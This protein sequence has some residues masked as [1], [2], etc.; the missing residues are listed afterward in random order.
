MSTFFSSICA[1]TTKLRMSTAAMVLATESYLRS[2]TYSLPKCSVTSVMSRYTPMPSTF[3]AP[4]LAKSER[5]F[6]HFSSISPSRRAS[7]RRVTSH[8]EQRGLPSKISVS[9]AAAGDAS[10][11]IYGDQK[12]KG[13]AAQP[14][15]ADPARA[16]R[17][18]ALPCR[19]RGRLQRHDDHGVLV[20]GRRRVPR[21]RRG[22]RAALDE[23]VRE[24]ADRGLPRPRRDSDQ[25]AAARPAP[26]S[27]ARPRR[28]PPRVH[29]RRG[30]RRGGRGGWRPRGQ[31]GGRARGVR[32]GDPRREA[33]KAAA[34]P[35]PAQHRQPRGR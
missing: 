25:A 6:T 12:L 22:A 35:L 23:R 33:A 34:H 24:R 10:E 8:T 7:M 9:L 26:Q 3:T 17:R 4:S 1:T 20:R 27:H 11:A 32:R 16:G 28:A 15:R 21:G 14:R 2:S 31:A 5:M 19:V 30:G 13:V 18:R 29:R